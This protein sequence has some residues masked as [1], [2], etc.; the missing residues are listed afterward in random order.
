MSIIQS[1]SKLAF[2]AFI[3]LMMIIFLA[4]YLN[5]ASL[6]ERLEHWVGQAPTAPPASLH[7]QPDGLPSLSLANLPASGPPSSSPADSAANIFKQAPAPLPEGPSAAPHILGQSAAPMAYPRSVAEY[8]PTSVHQGITAPLARS[9]AAARPRPLA[10]KIR[11]GQ[12]LLERSRKLGREPQ[13]L[14]QLPREKM[15]EFGIVTA[16]PLLVLFAS[17]IADRIMRHHRQQ[18]NAHPH[19]VRHHHRD[20]REYHPMHGFHYH[21]YATGYGH[22]A[23]PEHAPYHKL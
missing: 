2:S 9:E 3:V 16:I 12:S 4:A 17:L 11:T 13:P 23:P 15:L 1:R 14:R 20:E 22:H 19:P 8:R 21:H 18:Q 10:E 5:R 6:G 7:H